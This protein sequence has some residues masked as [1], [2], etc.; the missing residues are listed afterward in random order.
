MVGVTEQCSN[1]QQ[2][3]PYNQLLIK[4]SKLY[5]TASCLKNAQKTKNDA[6]DAYAVLILEL[7]EFEAKIKASPEVEGQIAKNVL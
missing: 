7:K 4:K 5:C 2:I 1:C 3:F 6:L